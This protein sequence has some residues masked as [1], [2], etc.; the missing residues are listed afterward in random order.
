MSG[1]QNWGS[2]SMAAVIFYTYDAYDVV[3]SQATNLK[4]LIIRIMKKS[5]VLILLTFWVT[6]G[7]STRAC[8]C[9]DIIILNHQH[10]SLA[11]KFSAK[12]VKIIESMH[13]CFIPYFL[14][15]ISQAE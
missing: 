7:Y 10:L 12:G 14:S 2:A 11:P 6:Y 1:I 3:L 8:L 9:F 15:P 13:G 4:P 5:C